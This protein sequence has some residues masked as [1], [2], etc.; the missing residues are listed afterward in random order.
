VTIVRR[1]PLLA[2]LVAA[3]FVIAFG[4]ATL[5]R[6]Q[7]EGSDRGVPPIDS[8]ANYEVGGV[9]V[10]VTA[11]TSEQ[12]RSYG[13]RLA[14]R[15]AW[16]TL[17]ARVNGQPVDAA[18]GLPDGTLDSITA[19]IAVEDEEIGAHRYIA[20]LGVL[21]DRNRAGDLLGARGGGPRS[22]PMLVIPVMWSGGVAQ[23]FEKRTEWQK[24]WARFRSGGSPID[25]VRPVGSGIDPLVLNVAQAGRPG[26][27]QW[28][29]LLEQYGAADV[30]VPVVQIVRRWPG[31]PVVAHFKAIHGPDG[32]EIARFDLAA[33]DARAVPAMLDEGVRR[34]DEALSAALRAGGLISDPTL[35]AEP[36]R[37][38][39]LPEDQ[40]VM[41]G[42]VAP[43]AAATSL[44]PVQSL[45]VQVDTPD[46]V[47]RAA[48]EAQLRGVLG[49]R[50]VSTT[51]LALGG[52][53]VMRVEYEGDAAALRA[54]LAPRGLALDEGLRLRRAVP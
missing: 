8:S 34:I 25:Y 44:A 19:G 22:A 48:I 33:A 11:K 53:S 32:E 14:Q 24:A 42:D 13:W 29:A 35:V 23:S 17:W 28:R 9:Q 40:A 10:D 26:R 50:S 52:V 2:G 51:S 47:A 30:V 6:A 31:G 36:A 4:M 12:A 27:G 7:I 38:E 54:A 21:F 15:K 1:N 46:D 18:P 5:L 41:E 16:K 37:I 39:A 3:L 49:V 20:R 45:S 43:V